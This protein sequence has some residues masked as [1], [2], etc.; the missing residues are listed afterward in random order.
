[1]ASYE[2]AAQTGESAPG[3]LVVCEELDLP[4]ETP[5]IDPGGMFTFGAD[6][7]P[8]CGRAVGAR[9]RDPAECYLS[10][11]RCP[12]WGLASHR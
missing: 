7:R 2:R 11:T 8:G 10:M 5:G 4:A 1:M 3:V 12:T 9:R 6:G